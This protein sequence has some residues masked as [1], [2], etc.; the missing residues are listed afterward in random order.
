MLLQ[1]ALF[2]SGLSSILLCVCVYI[3]MCV[4]IY[5]CVCVYITCSIYMCIYIIHTHTRT[6]PFFIH[7]SVDGHLGRVHVIA[8]VNSAAVNIGVHIFF[9][10]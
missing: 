1:M 2:H 8:I 5:I 10:P 4:C 7:A 3:H 9:K 6:C